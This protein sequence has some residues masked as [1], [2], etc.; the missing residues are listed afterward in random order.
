MAFSI[1]ELWRRVVRMDDA[2]ADAGVAAARRQEIEEEFVDWYA[3]R[4]AAIDDRRPASSPLLAG[5][6]RERNARPRNFVGA[7]GS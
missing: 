7:G 5:G 4:R 2:L 6:A 1:S 3:G